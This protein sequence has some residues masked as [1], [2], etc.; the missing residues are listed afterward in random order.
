ML[1]VSWVLTRWVI[2]IGSKAV[3]SLLFSVSS[4]SLW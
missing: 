4:V 2:G 1:A 3:D